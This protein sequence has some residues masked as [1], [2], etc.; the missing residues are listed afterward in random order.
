VIFAV[1]P[2]NVVAVDFS[3]EIKAQGRFFNHSSAAQEDLNPAL[4]IESKLEGEFNEGYWKFAPFALLDGQDQQRSHIDIRELYWSGYSDEFEWKIGISRVFWGV[5]ESLHLVDI[6]N[7]QDLIT[8]IDGETKLGQPMV[9]FSYQTDLGLLETY[10]LPCYRKLVFG[11]N[12]SR[13]QLF[14]L[15][16]EESDDLACHK[17][18]QGVDWAVRWSQSFDNTDI[19]IS[20]FDG[21]QRTPE[22]EFSIDGSIQIQYDLL[23]QTSLELLQ[24]SGSWIYKFEALHRRVKQQSSYAW[25][26]GT[27]YT[28]FGINGSRS[29]LGLLFEYQYDQARG[30]LNDHDV[31]IAARWVQND[32]NDTEILI[33]LIVDVKKTASKSVRIEYKQ[34]INNSF[35]VSANAYAFSSSDQFEPGYNLRNEDHL[36]VS[37]SYYF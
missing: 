20:Y 34:R 30:S 15:E 24:I 10:I 12:K 31:F 4:I 28:L 9:N 7:Q 35:S 22:F 14:D 29:D 37:L 17:S 25:V 5:T 13:L 36:S 26:G 11:G 2:W 27:E 21:M 1:V 32:V 19:A 3:S 23:T 6:I 8:E 18:E 33:G 16:L